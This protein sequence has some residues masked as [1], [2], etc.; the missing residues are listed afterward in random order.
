MTMETKH[1]LDDA[2]LAKVQDLIEVNVDSFNGFRQAAENTKDLSVSSLFTRISED[3]VQQA[4]ELQKIVL[5]NDVEAE[6]TGSLIGAIHRVILDW[7]AYFD[8]GDV[9]VLEEA[10]RGEDYIKKQY[11]EALQATAGSAV[12]DV[13]NRH[14]VAVKAAHDRVRDVRDAKK[15]AA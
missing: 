13:L 1:N 11:E 14:F 4:I 15:N 10:E 9:C 7:R 8:K 12:T 2:T 5:G 6:S 3:R